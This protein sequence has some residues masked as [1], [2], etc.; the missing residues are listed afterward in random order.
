MVDLGAS[1]ITLRRIEY[2]I[3]AEQAAI[4][5]AG[6]PELLASRLGEGR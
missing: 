5:A 4:R 2:D 1:T 6:L 3:A